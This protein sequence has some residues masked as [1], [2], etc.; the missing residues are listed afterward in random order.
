MSRF[1]MVVDPSLCV[2]CK[3]CMVACT[4]EN[5]VPV[6]K[7]RNWVHSELRGSY[8]SAALRSNTWLRFYSGSR[9]KDWKDEKVSRSVDKEKLVTE[10]DCQGVHP[11][12]AQRAFL[13]SIGNIVKRGKKSNKKRLT[14]A[15]LGMQVTRIRIYG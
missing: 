14:P 3:A 5:D 6:G 1:A 11:L 8:Q 9:V 7:H 13:K 2:D 10:V 4:A 15:L 12:T